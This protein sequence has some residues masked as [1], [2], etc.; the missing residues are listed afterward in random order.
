MHKNPPKKQKNIVIFKSCTLKAKLLSVM[1]LVTLTFMVAFKM[2]NIPSA[3]WKPSF[4]PSRFDVHYLGVF[5]YTFLYFV[6]WEWFRIRKKVRSL[7]ILEEVAL[8]RTS[9]MKEAELNRKIQ[10]Q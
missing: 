8:F 10:L 2:P 7:E 4:P 6:K 9:E 3:Y 1:L 5:L